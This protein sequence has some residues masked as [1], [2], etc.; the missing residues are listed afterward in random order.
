MRKLEELE[1]EVLT[2]VSASKKCRG[3]CGMH[4]LPDVFNTPD[5]I[6]KIINYDRD[7]SLVVSVARVRR[8]LRDLRKIG[9][10]RYSAGRWYR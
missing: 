8:I 3:G 1:R 5:G 7:P 2:E 4:T 9:A 10:V 6:A